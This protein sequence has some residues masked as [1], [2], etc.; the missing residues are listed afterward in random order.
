M[1]AT[2]PGLDPGTLK[3]LATCFLGGPENKPGCMGHKENVEGLEVKALVQLPLI[4]L[5]QAGFGSPGL[6]PE[7]RWSGKTALGLAGE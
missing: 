7:V 3:F 2:M 4:L 1:H 5:R 6:S